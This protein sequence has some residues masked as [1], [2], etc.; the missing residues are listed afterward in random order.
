MLRN[1]LD[2][3]LRCRPMR[4][5]R[6]VVFNVGRKPGFGAPLPRGCRVPHGRADVSHASAVATRHGSAASNSG[7]TRVRA[8]SKRTRGAAAW[9]FCWTKPPSDSMWPTVP[10]GASARASP[11][12]RCGTVTPCG[13][14]IGFKPTTLLSQPV[15]VATIAPRHEDSTKRMFSNLHAASGLEADF[16]AC[17]YPFSA[18]RHDSPPG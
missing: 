3:N 6:R 11:L 7:N 10:C 15:D 8:V 12:Q 9:P 2:A 5:L 18:N 4:R 1:A 13:A 14:H 16:A 17:H